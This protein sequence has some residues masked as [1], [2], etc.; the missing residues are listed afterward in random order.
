MKNS[1]DLSVGTVQFLAKLIS[2]VRLDPFDGEFE[3]DVLAIEELKD[4]LA[5]EQYLHG[6]RESVRSGPGGD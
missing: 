6:G 1:I 3:K 4:R 2:F 5:L